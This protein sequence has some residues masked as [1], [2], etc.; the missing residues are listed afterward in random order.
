MRKDS[1]TLER[2][3]RRSIENGK[4]LAAAGAYLNV[5]R[6]FREFEQNGKKFSYED[7][8]LARQIGQWIDNEHDAIEK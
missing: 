1:D 2:M 3:Q 5:L 4:H 7:M 8:I 6:L